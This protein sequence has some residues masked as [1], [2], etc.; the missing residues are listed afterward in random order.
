[1]KLRRKCECVIEFLAIGVVVFDLSKFMVV[2]FCSLMVDPATAR[3]ER[4]E[5]NTERELS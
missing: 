4:G 3:S 2:V 5:E 1:M